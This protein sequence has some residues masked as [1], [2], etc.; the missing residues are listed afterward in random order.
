MAWLND[1]QIV[2]YKGMTCYS[3]KRGYPSNNHFYFKMGLYRDLMPQT[4]SLFIDDYS[5]KELT[6]K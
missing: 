6:A 3:E 5:K 4:M 1:K 2:N